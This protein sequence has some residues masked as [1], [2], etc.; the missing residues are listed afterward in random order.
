VDLAVA[1]MMRRKIYVTV[2]DLAETFSTN[3]VREIFL[4]Q[5][6]V[7]SENNYHL[8]RENPYFL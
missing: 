2:V 6:K 8:L 5:G 1:K 7:R 4:I 3:N